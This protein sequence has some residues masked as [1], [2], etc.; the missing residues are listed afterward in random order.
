MLRPKILLLCAIALVLSLICSVYAGCPVG[1]VHQD[2]DCEVNWLDLRDFAEQWLNSGCSA[3]ACGADLDGVPGVT[4]KDYAL[5][6]ENWLKRGSATLL[7]NEFMADNEGTIEDPDESGEYPDWIEIYNYGDEAID[8]GGMYLTDRPLNQSGWRRI[9]TDDPGKTTIEAGG[10]LVFWADDD[11]EQGALHLNFKISAGGGEDIGLFDWSKN[12]LDIVE[13]DAQAP[14]KSRGRLPDGSDNWITFEIGGATPGYENRRKPVEVL[15]SE[16]MYHPGHA[17]NT[18]E[19]IGEEYIELYNDGE[20]PVGLL[21]WRF[22]NGINYTITDDIILGVGR[23]YVI[24]SNV[25]AFLAKYPGVTN[26]VGGWTGRL[27]NSGEEIELVDHAGVLVDVVQYA[28]QGDWAIRELGPVDFEHRGWVWADDH[29]GDGD[30]LELINPGLSNEYGQNWAASTGSGGTP[31][32][33]NSVSASDIAP[34]ILDMEHFP[35]IPGP[36]DPV[37]VTARIIDELA[38]GVTVTLHHRLDGEPTFNMATMFDDGAH[39]DGDADDGVYAGEI[40]AQADGE[41]VEF[42]VRASDA[43]A[44]S[45][46]WPAASDVDGT[47]EQVTNALYQIDNSYN[48]DAPWVPGSQPVYYIIMIETERAELEDIG[49]GGDPFFGEARSN[50][51]MNATFISVDG[52]DTKLRYSAGVRNR[53]NRTRAQPPNNFRVNFAHDK[54]WKGVTAL[55]INSKYPH[56]QVMGS[57]IFRLAG[58]PA[59]EATAVQLRVNGENLAESDYSRMYNSYVAMEAYDSDWAD[60]HFPDD[61]AGNLYRC[62]YVKLATGGTTYADLDYKEPPGETPDPDDYRDNYPKQTNSSQHDYSDLFNLIDK[63]NNTGIPDAYLLEEVGQVANLDQWMRYMATDAFAGNREGGLYEGE[64]DDYAMYRGAIDPRF[65]LLPHD[66]DTL[67]GQGDHSYAPDWEI[68]SY[69]DV[70]GLR[71]L[72][73][74][75]EIWKAYYSQYRDLAR[76]VFA[77]A[78]LHPLVDQLL[79]S[80]VPQSEIEGT[81][82]IKQFVI[83]RPKSILYG[84]YPG[85]TDDPQ[86]PQA[87]TMDCDLPVVSGFHRTTSSVVASGNIHGRA[88]AIE[89]VSVLVNGRPANWSQRYGTWVLNEGL[90]LNP[91]INRIFVRAFDAPDGGGNELENGYVDIW[92]DT[93][94]TNDYP[95]TKGAPAAAAAADPNVNMI[96]RD[97]YLPGIPVLVRIELLGD[98]GG[99][100]RGI[101]DATATLS[102]DNPG[103]SLSA[104]QVTLYNGLGSLSVTFTGSGD[105]TLTA[106]VMGLEI[107]KMLSDLSGEPITTVSGSLSSS[108]TWSGVYHITGGDYAIPG[109]V[110]LTLNPGTLVLIDGVASGDGG[111]DIDVAGAIRS[112]GTAA[113]PLTFTAYGPGENWGE[114]DFRNAELSTFEYTNITG[115]GHSP[116]AGHSNSGPTIRASGTTLVFDY[117]SLTDNAGKLMHVTSDSD[118]TFRHCLFARSIMG[119]EISGTALLFEDSWITDMHAADDGDGIYIHGQQAGQVCTLINGVAANIDDDAIDTLGSD[120]L[121]ENFIVRDCKDKGISVYGGETTIKHCL[122]VENNRAPEDPTITTVAAKTTEGSTATVNIDRTT[123][124]TSKVPGYTDIGIQSHNKYGVSSGTI[125]YNVT[126]SIIDAT[127]PIDVESPYLESDIHVSYSDIYDE[128]WS[129]LGNLRVDPLFSDAANHDYT[130]EETSPCIDAGDPAAEPDPDLTAI[131]QGYY[132]FD[133]GY[134]ELPEGSLTEDTIWTAA[135]GPYRIIGELTVPFGITLT[136][137]PGTTVFFEPSAKI[138]VAGRFLAEG[139]EYELLRFTRTPGDSGMWDGLQFIDTIRDN[140]IAYAIVEYGQTNDGMI[141]LDES[142]LLLDHVTLDNTERRR[143]RTI[144]SSLIVRDCLFTNIFAPGQA[145]STDN[146]SE[147]IWGRA[148]DTGW[149]IIENNVFGLVPGHNDAIDIDGPSR[150]NPIPQIL[151]NTFLGGGDDALDLETDAHIEGNIFYNFVKDEWNTASGESNVISAGD[152]KDYVMIRNAFFNAQHVAQVKDDAFLTFVNNTVVDVCE[153]AIYFDLDLP[154]RTPGRGACVEGTIFWNTPMVFAG[155]V[156]TTDLTVNNSTIAFEWHMYGLGNIDADPLLIDDQGDFRLKPDSGAIGTGSWGLDMGAMVPAGAAISGEPYAVTYRTDATLTVGGPGIVS[157]KYLLNIPIGPWSA[158]RAV[159]V[160]VVLTGLTNGESYTVYA[161]GKNSA[162]VWQSDDSP[163]AS[164]T[165]TIDTSHSQLVINEVLAHT[166][167]ADPDVIELYYDGPAPIDLT[168]MGLT[169]DPTE[170]AKFEFNSSS[171][172]TT[173]MNPGDYM[174]LYGDLTTYTNHLGFALS[175]DGEGLYLYD[176]ANPDGSHDLLDSV[177]FGPQI[178]DHSIGR[179]G[180]DR[181]WKLNKLTFGTANIAQPLGDP[182]TLKINEW[183]ANGQVLFDDDFVELYNPHPQPAALGGMYLTDNPVTQPDEHRIVEL[184]FIPPQ[185]FTVFQ[186]NDG[187]DPSELDFK[188]SSDGEMIGLF[189]AGLN[190]ID[191]VLYGP[192]TTDVS[193][194][195]APDGSSNYEFFGLPT[196][197]VSNPQPPT[198]ITT[199]TVLA[200]ENA[201]KRAIIPTSAGH[202][203]ETWKADPDFDD[204]SWLPCIGSPGGVGF[205]T[206]PT[207]PVNYVSLITCDVETQM[208]NNNETCYIRIPFTVDGADLADFTGM[209]LKIRYDDGF[210]PYI[211][212]VELVT[213]RRNFS[214]TPQ[215]DSGASRGHSDSV[216]V[217]FEYI[218]VSGYLSALRSGDNVLAIHGLNDGLNSSDFLISAELE[219]S[220]TEIDPGSFPYEDDLDVLAGLRITELMYNA[221]SGSNFD[222]IELQNISSIPIQL[223]GVRFVDGIEFE[224]P[225]VQLNAGEYIVVVANLTAFRNYYGYTARVAGQYAGGL[226]GGGEDIVLVLAWP[227]EAAIMRFEY[228]DT[229]YPT[230]DGGGHSLTINDATAHPSLWDDAESWHAAFP[231]PGGP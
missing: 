80:W 77:P 224:F 50:A 98:D 163:T 131:D 138:I 102:V 127:D 204:S 186:A 154:G 129:G 51:Q 37:T 91:G 2:G 130:L 141:G 86:I 199:T 197:G 196:P 13:F 12:P 209:T 174:I 74:Q 52:V 178:N 45:R 21:G 222:Y 15:I 28:D 177:E 136:I 132:W 229:W 160:P 181:E 25:N 5:L 191:Q 96:V 135:E 207:D 169:D 137:M 20:E 26:V 133:Q 119:P 113:S 62:T 30:S 121:I 192:Q 203:G 231:S 95:K 19:N 166:H 116:R 217:L 170:P 182:D 173:T 82:G 57:A 180:W 157:Y 43:A 158:E 22:T 93:G 44:N 104:D 49:D 122:V 17:E 47:P 6:A 144:D 201:T 211:N 193:Q 10:Y 126:N 89:T 24:A 76:T 61:D 213:A 7:I 40:P 14:D 32:A 111:T 225:A 53:G 65:W 16:I 35:I 97:S 120:I 210:V 33:T 85:S 164:H 188:L 66:L 101:W 46:T 88:N 226:S 90:A 220:V 168:G 147:H 140:R 148:S 219:A 161:I 162:G 218:D 185:G 105:F 221:P 179:V 134:I 68:F 145:P 67:F 114:I 175:A 206:H 83:E 200:P 58:M 124:V 84:G 215:W 36:S 143:I 171:V 230:T 56:L 69:A 118:L 103:V 81:N 31:G 150:P 194:G 39:G 54:S 73:D 92:Y 42:Y 214:G 142:R 227:L 41:I 79:A 125:T 156:G 189:D 117:S 34:L 115:A 184:S 167:G 202:V 216:A 107:N 108:A 190:L 94:I 63:L 212:G 71:R 60:N 100:D 87:F 172:L 70:A 149:F 78:N 11:T 99:I 183:F 75:D 48:A 146:M 159:E 23:Y 18:P 208:D 228:N 8:M 195:R 9:P 72:F 29:D 38:T 1:D 106:S 205:E 112:L 3:P 123:I 151:N 128:L 165:W 152:G 198:L 155:V 187:N 27:S 4:M 176:K 59:P 153:A 55:T 223:D 139:S 64:G 110:T 109:G